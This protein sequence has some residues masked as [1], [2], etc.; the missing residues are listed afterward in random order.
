MTHDLKNQR[1]QDIFPLGT[2]VTI[3]SDTFK[4]ERGTVEDAYRT[5]VADRP[6]V[7]VRLDRHYSAF[8]KLTCHPDSL[9]HL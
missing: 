3:K 2:R 9:K 7:V 5:Y 8:S 6:C 4:G 1:L